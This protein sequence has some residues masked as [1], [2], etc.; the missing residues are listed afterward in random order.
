MRELEVNKW[1]RLGQLFAVRPGNDEELH[2]FIRVVLGIDVP[3]CA[4]EIGNSGPFEYVKHVYFE[5]KGSKTS[6][7]EGGGAE[8]LNKSNA[9]QNTKLL[10]TDSGNGDSI[11]ETSKGVGSEGNRGDGG[12]CVV[13]A[14]R[15]GGKTMLGAV[16]TL[17]DLMFKPGIQVRI[18]GGSL[19]QSGRMYD[20]LKE[21]LGRPLLKGIVKG[22]PTQR[23]IE[24][25]N[26]S[27]VE[28]LSQ[29]QRSVRGVRVHKLR[30][31]EVE[32]FDEDI[33]EA[34]QLV[35]RSG[36]CGDVWV[37]GSV[38]ALSTMHRLGGLM[39]KLVEQGRKVFR[40]NAID[41]MQRCDRGD[42]EVCELIDDCR[43]RGKNADGFM[44]VDDLICQIKR[45]SKG[46]WESEMMCERP[47][48]DELVYPMF[49]KKAHAR[50]VIDDVSR[51]ERLVIGGMDFGIRS[52]AVF[53]LAEVSGEE[54]KKVVHVVGEYI[55]SGMRL[56][57][58]VKRAE[59]M[60]KE[61]GVG[62]PSWLGVDP[63]GLARNAHTGMSDVSVLRERGYSVRSKRV[64]LAEG[65]ELVRRMLEQE[66]LFVHPRCVGL[67]D[68]LRCYHFDLKH[69]FNDDPV[70]D[71]PDH[72]C[73]ALRYMLQNMSSG[74]MKMQRFQ[75]Y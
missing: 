40:W 35:T 67:I 43:G 57:E 17:L 52:P 18:L 53:L 60:R 13:W 22:E 63:A 49:E 26:G 10:M 3:K 27:R 64:R 65:V 19:E 37:N 34:A 7:E 39:G 8:G 71:G 9:E 61:L 28:I 2:R 70:K 41:V 74:A 38:E 16:V 51:R 23:K 54:D 56:A 45:T 69:Q 14:N 73:D 36:W 66:Q 20:H 11:Y 44:R 25:V 30:C 29:S 6:S 47:R 31:D 5:G 55:E 72:A 46:T 48:R 68:A 32:E 1:G 4:I 12:D 33:W 24:L 59:E 21:L 75:Y 58:H 62:W 50:E 42:C 15:G